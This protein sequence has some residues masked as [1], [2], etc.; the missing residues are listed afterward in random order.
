MPDTSRPAHPCR[1]TALSLLACALLAPAAW[2]QGR[3]PEKPVTFIVPFA[4]GSGTDA[5]ARVVAKSLGERLKQ[6]VLVD[7][8]AGASGQLAAQFVADAKPDGYTL[9]MTTNTPHSA[10]PSLF[11]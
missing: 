2:A 11:R 8:R 7:N 9:M 1:R 3:F 10:N 5:V 6:Q 4:A